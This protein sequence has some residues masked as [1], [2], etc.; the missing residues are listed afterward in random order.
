MVT[1]TTS[2]TSNAAVTAASGTPTGN[3]AAK[4]AAAGLIKALGSGSGVDVNSLANSLV[5]AEKA[6][7]KAGLDAKVAKAEGGISGYAAVKYVLGDLQTAFTNLKNESS[8]NTLVPLI[9]QPNAV[10]VT[11]SASAAMGNHTVSITQLAQQQR[12]ISADNVAGFASPLS[13]VN[14]GLAFSLV[15]KNSIDPTPT[16]VFNLG[17]GAASTSTI[18]FKAMNKGDTV[19]VNGL[20]LTANKSLNASEVG[21]LFDQFDTTTEASVAAGG[22]AASAINSDALATFGTFSGL[23]ATGYSSGVNNNG[24]VILTSTAN[25]TA[26]IAS[27]T[28]TQFSNTIAVADTATT[29]AGI[30][31]AINSASL[32]IKAQLINTGNIA[33]PYRI[34][35]TGASGV[36]NAFSL[37]S[38]KAEEGGGEVTGISFGKKLQSSQDATFNV[39]GMDMTSSKNTVTDAIAGATL[40][41]NSITTAGVPA[42]LVFSRDTSSIS[43]KLNALVTAYN[44]ANTML[45]VVSDPKSTVETF[46]ATLVGNSMVGSVRNQMRQLIT[47]N[48][49]TPAGGLTAL[50]DI[51]F[52]LDQKGVL[53]LDKTKLASALNN[54]FDNVVTLVTGNRENQSKFSV[55]PSGVAGEAVKKLSA[56]LDTTAPLTTQSTNLTTKI[57]EYKKQLSKLDIRMTDL[58]ARYN[59]QFATMESMVGESKS[60]QTSLKSTFEGMMAAYTNK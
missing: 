14:G 11:T 51:G 29:P 19:T 38:L 16:K 40:S 20:T 21:E 39:D 27:P 50:R 22:V 52:N 10:S 5:A 37:T 2:S 55:L 33:T 48:S 3:E 12:S 43:T 7:R 4:T 49:T 54:S 57:S 31:A 25:N 60:L 46:G 42:N 1:A 56:L 58:L 26:D 18:T 35:V 17:N 9:S 47:G 28:G 30:V 36:S 44:D 13:Q 45:G 34:M 23:F 41:F 6:P 59:K 32:G 8:F 53:S 15:L 24:V